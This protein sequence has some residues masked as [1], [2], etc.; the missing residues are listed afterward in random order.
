MNEFK[1]LLI[2]CG[3]RREK[4]LFEGD[5]RSFHDLT[6]LDGNADHRPDVV[7]DLNVHPLPFED[8]TFHEIHA[9]EVLEHLGSQ[10]DYAFFFAEFTEYWRILKPDG[11]FFATVPAAESPWVW[12][13]PSH[14][15]FFAPPWLLFLSQRAYDEQIGCTGMSDFR[16][17][18]KADFITEYTNTMNNG[19]TFAFV[20]RAVKPS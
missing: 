13:D 14:T 12:G 3:S 2:G 20:L 9:Y 18:Y 6:T 1:E 5:N 11:R 19:E 16:Y 17:L 15:R 8:N 4:Y 7:H 10:G